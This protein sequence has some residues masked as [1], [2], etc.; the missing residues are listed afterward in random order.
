MSNNAITQKTIIYPV[1]IYSQNDLTREEGQ[2]KKIDDIRAMVKQDLP[3]SL[4]KRNL[5]KLILEY[6]SRLLVKYLTD[7]ITMPDPVTGEDFLDKSNEIVEPGRVSLRGVKI[8]GAANPNSTHMVSKDHIQLRTGLYK[9]FLA[10]YR[11]HE[12][13][14]DNE[15]LD[16]HEFEINDTKYVSANVNLTGNHTAGENGDSQITN[17]PNC[18]KCLAIVADGISSRGLEANA[19]TGKFASDF[20][21][22]NFPRVF[23]E[24][25]DKDFTLEDPKGTISLLPL[26]LTYDLA[27]QFIK[28]YFDSSLHNI[29]I[30]NLDSLRVSRPNVA[31]DVANLYL[32]QYNAKLVFGALRYEIK[33]RDNSGFKNGFDPQQ[34]EDQGD[35]NRLN[36]KRDT[37][38][39]LDGLS[40]SEL[41]DL[42]FKKDY[43]SS[44]ELKIICSIQETI[45]QMSSAFESYLQSKKLDKIPTSIFGGSTFASAFDLGENLLLC[46]VGDSKAF[47]IGENGELLEE[48][49]TDEHCEMNYIEDREELNSYLG[50]EFSDFTGK[51][52]PD[53]DPKVSFKLVPKDKVK[54][55]VLCSDGFPFKDSKSIGG[56]SS[57]SQALKDLVAAMVKDS[58]FLPS[59][60]IANALKYAFGKEWRGHLDDKTMVVISK[61]ELTQSKPKLAKAS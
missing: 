17:P 40:E 16:N 42:I 25:L 45:E 11:E 15:A 41:E 14:H 43:K 33:P 34:Y 20:I 55:I 59:K 22:R 38:E 7:V 46:G 56:A 52:N 58:D 2:I 53:I 39:Y 28:K 54:S 31:E 51:A 21:I 27:C 37:V 29:L 57:I 24:N 36:L 8:R 18:P 3:D 4:D 1:N 49:V 10:R 26:G 23:L 12:V 48:S 13:I 9:Y 50:V 5:D 60:M 6:Q 61:E 47:A 44:I 32:E 35:I 19:Y 30:K